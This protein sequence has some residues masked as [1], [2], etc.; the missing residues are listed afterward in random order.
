MAFLLNLTNPT[1]VLS[2]L[3]VLTVL[4]LH[5]QKSPFEGGALV[6]AIFVG[7]MLWW[8]SLALIASR[9]QNRLTERAMV[10]MNRVAGIAIGS[11]GL[12]TVALSHAFA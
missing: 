11:F 8:I 9:F 4:G 12:L 2:F 3:A 7:A 10:I 1:T 5:Q 6:A